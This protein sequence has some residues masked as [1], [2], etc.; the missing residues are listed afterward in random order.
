MANTHFLTMSFLMETFL[1][2]LAYPVLPSHTNDAPQPPPSPP[3]FH[4][5]TPRIRT[6]AGQAMDEDLRLKDARKVDRERTQSVVAGIAVNESDIVDVAGVA[7]NVGVAE[8]AV[9][10]NAVAVAVDGGA[11]AVAVDGD[12]VVVAVDGG[13]DQVQ[14]DS[15]DD[16]EADVL[17]NHCFPADT[18][19]LRAIAP[20]YSKIHRSFDLSKEPFSYPEALARPDAPVWRA[21]MD[22]EK[23]SLEAMGAFE[24]ADLPDGERAIG[25]KWV[26]AYKT[27]SDGA[28]IR[29]K[30]KARVVA[31]GFN[32]R[33]GQYDET[34]APV[35]KMASV[36]ILLTWAAVRDLEIYQFDCKTAFL[37]AKIRHPIYARQIPGYPL[38][39]AQKVLRVLVALYGLRQSAYEFYMLFL[40]LLLALGM[41]RCEVDHGVFLGEWTSPPDSSVPMPIDG[42]PLVLYVPL[43]VDDGLAITNSTPLYLWFLNTLAKRLLIVD[44][45]QC[46]KFLSILILR[47]RPHRRMWLSSH[48][49]VSELL[50]EWNLSSCKPAS[51]P[52]PSH[53]KELPPAPPNSLPDISDAELTLKYQR[54]IGCLLYL[55]VATRPDIAY[56]AMWL[57]QFNAAPS[58]THFLAAKHVLRYLSGTKSLALCLGTPSSNVPST[59]RG[60]LQNVGCSDADWASDAVDRKSISGYS[61]YFEGSLVSWSAVKQKSIALSSTEAE[62]YAMTHAFKE[63]LWLRAFLGLVKL[64]FPRPFPILCDNQAACSLSNSPAISARSKHIDIRHHFIRDHVQAGS[65][66]TTWIPTEDMPADIFT[67]VLPFPSF[68]RHRDVL[69]LSV[70]LTLL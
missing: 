54:L 31:Q 66:S 57:G 26:Y 7:V 52:F 35:A 44:L 30:E 39:N 41:V 27:D 11:V 17:W 36:R 6:I 59:L 45:G 10:E 28:I 24:E 22:R 23:A 13:V 33:P 60:Y 68:S 67:K 58:R 63:G 8:V 48:I 56:Y 40:S 42:T 34:Y 49:Y 65:F 47:D 53:I 61:F 32:Q 25:L 51:T 38:S 19:A 29:G 5:Q 1:A 21:A 69:G 70:P 20:S 55:A 18:V 4:R 12:D 15:L 43:H 14:T 50:G 9:C 2:V 37:H 62:Y 64:P 3:R 16:L 46:S